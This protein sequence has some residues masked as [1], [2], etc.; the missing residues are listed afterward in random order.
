MALRAVLF[1]C[2]AIPAS[3][4]NTLRDFTN[5]LQFDNT[6]RNVPVDLRPPALIAFYDTAS[7]EQVFSVSKMNFPKAGKGKNGG[8]MLSALRGNKR[9]E[10]EWLGY[11][12]KLLTGAYNVQR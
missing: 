9:P 4:V 11:R 5:S 2:A 8:G 3:S 1:V 12:A 10:S 7:A 6:V